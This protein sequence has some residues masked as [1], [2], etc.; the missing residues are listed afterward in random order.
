MQI[1]DLYNV[2][3]ESVGKQVKTCH[4]RR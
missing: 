3:I 4:W 2:L 1:I